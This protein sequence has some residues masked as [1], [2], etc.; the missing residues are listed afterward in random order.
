MA[1]ELIW[2]EVIDLTS[3]GIKYH[4]DWYYRFGHDLKRWDESVCESLGNYSNEEKAFECL[5]KWAE[6]KGIDLERV[7]RFGSNIEYFESDYSITVMPILELGLWYDIHDEL[8][9]DKIK[10][11]YGTGAMIVKKTIELDKD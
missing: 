10:Q 2:Y 11:V 4:D 1:K 6:E 9:E 5:K 3:A 7:E 8:T